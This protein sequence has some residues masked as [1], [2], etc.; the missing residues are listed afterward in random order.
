MIL[1]LCGCATTTNQMMRGAPYRTYTSAHHRAD[2]AECIAR[3]IPYAS[4]IPGR[5]ETTVNQYNFD[6]P[7][8]FTWVIS[9]AGSGSTIRL[10]RANAIAGGASAAEPCF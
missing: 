2:I 6:G 4:V 5:T 8:I 3:S 10:W 7:L 9:D 1:S